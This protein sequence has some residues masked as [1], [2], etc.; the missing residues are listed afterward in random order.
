M[1]FSTNTSRFSFLTD[2]APDP[3]ETKKKP[4]KN[5]NPPG[6]A[7]KPGNAT[8]QGKK[9]KKKPAANVPANTKQIS[10]SSQKVV[11]LINLIIF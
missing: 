9:N 5:K 3:F 4:S 1:A 7:N 10:S 8:A 11:S 6:S 2:D